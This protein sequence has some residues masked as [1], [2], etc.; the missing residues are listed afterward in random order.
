MKSDRNTLR[1]L[2]QMEE[3]I[4]VFRDGENIYYLNAKGRELVNCDKVRKRTG[5][6]QHYLMRNY[7]Y[8][9]YGCP[10]TWK[11][12]IRI[13]SG[14]TKKDTVTCVADALFKQGSTYC[15]VEVDNTQKM[16]Q[17]QSK[18][19]RYKILKERA[20]FGMLAPKFIWITTTEYRK[21]ELLRMS[22]GL[23]VEVYVI[24]D[25]KVERRQQHA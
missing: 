5:N 16:K 22:E 15:I 25:F 9:A 18:I 12:E 11:N 24:S 4:S 20:A 3:Y 13:R 7:I 23:H 2:K 19:E 21:K 6:V 8:M 10:V 1:V 17:N 14:S